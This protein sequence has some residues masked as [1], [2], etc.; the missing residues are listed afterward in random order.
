MTRAKIVQCA[1]TYGAEQKTRMTVQTFTEIVPGIE[2]AAAT[3]QLTFDGALASSEQQVA[4]VS[5]KLASIGIQA[6]VVQ[7]V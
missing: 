6:D 7:P 1:V 3:Y 4:A 2:Q 5:E